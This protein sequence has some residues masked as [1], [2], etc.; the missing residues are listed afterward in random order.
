MSCSVTLLYREILREKASLTTLLILLLREVH[1]AIG[2]GARGTL[3][4]AEAPSSI[5][6]FMDV[7]YAMFVLYALQGAFPIVLGSHLFSCGLSFRAPEVVLLV[8]RR[9]KGLIPHKKRNEHLLKLSILV[10]PTFGCWTTRLL[11]PLVRTD[12]TERTQP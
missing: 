12:K 5:R 7:I 3:L 1:T 2:E 9:G 6:R 10:V 8:P 4:H 11:G